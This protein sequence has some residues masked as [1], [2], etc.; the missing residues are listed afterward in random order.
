MW[1]RN[2]F[3][4]PTV[5]VI[6]IIV[7]D[8]LLTTEVH[9][10]IKLTP[11]YTLWAIKHGG[12]YLTV[13]LILTDFSNNFCVV[14]IMNECFMQPWQNCPYQCNSVQT[15]LDKNRKLHSGCCT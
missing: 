11:V 9:K 15:L 5:V 14:L 12:L 8:R 6:I 13:W 3:I 4:R 10:P 2:L 7:R 1:Y